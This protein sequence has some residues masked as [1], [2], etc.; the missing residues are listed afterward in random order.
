MQQSSRERRQ[1]AHPMRQKHFTT[2]AGSAQWPASS[3][4]SVGGARGGSSREPWRSASARHWPRSQEG[5]YTW[6]DGMRMGRASV[7]FLP[8]RTPSLAVR[9]IPENSQLRHTAQNAWAVLLKPVSVIEK[10]SSG[11]YD[12]PEEPRET[13]QLPVMCNMAWT[14]GQEKKHGQKPK[15]WNR[16]P[17]IAR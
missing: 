12:G 4:Q 3:E 6:W 10:R 17:T 13:W 11:N 2:S 8:K 7:A 16:V 5:V 9:K 14:P 1:T 15:K